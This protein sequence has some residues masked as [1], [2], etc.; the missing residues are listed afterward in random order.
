[1]AN[2]EN[3]YNG[4]HH[5]TPPSKRRPARNHGSE[6]GRAWL[7]MFLRMEAATTRPRSLIVMI[8]GA[9]IRLLFSDWA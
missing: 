4:L 6:T 5:H 2:G 9:V 7:L 3:G 1:M 8:L